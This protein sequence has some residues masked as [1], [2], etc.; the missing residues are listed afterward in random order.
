MK[1]YT[2]L[3]NDCYGSFCISKDAEDLIKEKMFENIA[4][5]NYELRSNEI[6]VDVFNQLGSEKFSGHYAKIKAEE[7]PVIYDYKIEQY[8]GLETVYWMPQ[9]EYLL[10]LMRQEDFTKAIEYLEE[11]GCF[12]RKDLKEK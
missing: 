10:N 2:V 3:Y 12:L 4:N 6:I 7:V 9:K 5:Y 1:T 11:A 8:D